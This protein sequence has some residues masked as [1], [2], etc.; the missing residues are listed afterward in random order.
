MVYSV[1]IYVKVLLVINRY[2]IEL[3]VFLGCFELRFIISFGVINNV[4]RLF[5]IVRLKS[6]I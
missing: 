1:V 6:R 5:V 3:F 4:K 2:N